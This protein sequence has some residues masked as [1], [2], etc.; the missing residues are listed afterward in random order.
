MINPRVNISQLRV[1]PHNVPGVYFKVTTDGFIK[2]SF[3]KIGH[4]EAQGFFFETRSHCVAQTEWACG[5]EQFPCLSHL[6]D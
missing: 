5:L 6:R 2:I 4:L 3:I 1:P